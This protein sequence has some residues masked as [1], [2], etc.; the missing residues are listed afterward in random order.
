MKNYQS[1]NVKSLKN[2]DI[3]SVLLDIKIY[4]NDISHNLINQKN[5]YEPIIE[6]ELTSEEH[7]GIFI[8]SSKNKD[9]KINNI[10]ISR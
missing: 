8:Y 10:V 6:N 2:L 5:I 7:N 1:A 3:F 4:K 9:F